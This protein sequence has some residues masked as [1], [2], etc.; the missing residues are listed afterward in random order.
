VSWAD[1]KDLP[2][3][4]F[5]AATGPGDLPFAAGVLSVPRRDVPRPTPVD[6]RRHPAAPPE[7]LGSPVSGRGYWVEYAEGNATTAGVRP[8]DVIVSVGGIPVRSHQDLVG[9]VAGRSAGERTTVRILRNGQSV[10]LT[11]TFAPDL[12]R[13]VRP[14]SS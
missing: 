9:S 5:L 7:V 3:G 2:A 14:D 12:P 13:R 6:L 1:L 10:E 4:T 8:G 11:L